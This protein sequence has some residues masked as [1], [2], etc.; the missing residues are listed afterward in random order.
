MWVQVQLQ[1]LKLQISVPALNKEFFDSQTAKKGAFT[2][3]PTCDM[4][5][6]YC[7]IHRTDKHLV[8][9]SVIWTIQRNSW[10]FVDDL[11]GYGIEYR[12]SNL[13]FWFCTSFEKGFPWH[14]GN[15]TVW[16]NSETCTWNKKK[17]K[18]RCTAQIS[19]HSTAQSFRQFL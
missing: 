18:G 12:C 10:V 11:S 8:N 6:R 5:R 15:Y 7:Q 2:L 4:T 17:S 14:S 16:I 13:N 3:K 9:S 19:T 1:S